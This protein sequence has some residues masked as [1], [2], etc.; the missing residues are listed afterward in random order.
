LL[1]P[2]EAEGA[3]E[4]ILERSLAALQAREVAPTR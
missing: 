4:E 2:V 1:V 3:P